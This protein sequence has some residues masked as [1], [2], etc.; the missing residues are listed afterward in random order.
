MTVRILR[1][2]APYILHKEHSGEWKL[3]FDAQ[4]E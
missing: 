1:T 3:L 4:T 2:D